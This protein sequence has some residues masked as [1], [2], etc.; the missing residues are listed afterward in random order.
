MA[1]QLHVVDVGDPP[2]SLGKP[3]FVRIVERIAESSLGGQARP[4]DS[5]AV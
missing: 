2:K 5:T 3:W 4:T 1:D